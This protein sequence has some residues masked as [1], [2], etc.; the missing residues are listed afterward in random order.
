MCVY[1]LHVYKVNCMSHQRLLHVRKVNGMRCLLLL[2]PWVRVCT[3]SP[4]SAHELL[5][6]GEHQSHQEQG[7]RPAH[8]H[9]GTGAPPA[10]ARSGSRSPW[11]CSGLGPPGPPGFGCGSWPGGWPAS[12]PNPMSVI[13]HGWSN[14]MAAITRWTCGGHPHSQGQ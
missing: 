4:L 5:E 11:V 12:W 6:H 10:V 9:A 2:H 8:R 7:R 14:A 1:L 3:V 13:I